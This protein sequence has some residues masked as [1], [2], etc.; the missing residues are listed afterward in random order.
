MLFKIECGTCREGVPSVG[1]FEFCGAV[2]L[3]IGILDVV[4]SSIVLKINK[5]YLRHDGILLQVREFHQLV[6]V[7]VL[8]VDPYVVITI[9][10]I[11]SGACDHRISEHGLVVLLESLLIWKSWP[12]VLRVRNTTFVVPHFNI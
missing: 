10:I 1:H 11:N 4:N 6:A 12:G 7:D 3:D 8:A 9:L 5:E 2:L